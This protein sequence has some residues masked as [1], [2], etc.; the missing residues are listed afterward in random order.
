MPE[1]DARERAVKLLEQYQLRLARLEEETISSLYRAYEAARKELLAVLTDRMASIDPT[2]TEA[3]RR[4]ATDS[5]LFQAIETRMNQ[6]ERDFTSLMSGKIRQVADGGGDQ[7]VQEIEALTKGLGIRFMRFDIDELHLLLVQ[8][9]IDSIPAI[10]Q[11]VAQHIIHELRTGLALGQRFS[12]L[13]RRVL[14]NDPANQSTFRRGLTSA[15]LMVRRAVN[16]VNN[17][18]RML[19]MDQS[20]KQLP[21]LQKQ[22][23]E[24]I[25]DRTTKLSLQMHGQIRDIDKPFDLTSGPPRPFARKM[26][27]HP[28]HWNDRG[29]TA[30]YMPEWEKR[31][32]LK[33]SDM[34]QAAN[35]E[36]ARREK[37]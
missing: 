27:S 32:N 3:V 28:F 29:A 15:E 13:A 10:V 33:T 7:V 37:V 30:P 36:L 18:S 21:T 19:F 34:R 25:D 22:V 5:T 16:E 6:L 9:V 31:S 8:P 14:S 11:P 1:L 17:H 23:V 20:R 12:D 26:M 35:D 2:D 4:L 24:H